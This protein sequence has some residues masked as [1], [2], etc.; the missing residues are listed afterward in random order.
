MPSVGYQNSLMKAS[1]IRCSTNSGRCS[2]GSALSCIQP[3]YSSKAGQFAFLCLNERIYLKAAKYCSLQSFHN[4]WG[5][6]VMACWTVLVAPE[7][8]SQMEAHAIALPW[9]SLHP[10]QWP[11]LPLWGD[12]DPL[13]LACGDGYPTSL[14]LSRTAPSKG[15]GVSI[16][17][18]RWLGLPPVPCAPLLCL[19]HE[20][21]PLVM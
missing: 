12:G 3:V 18:V 16:V 21:K 9:R 4:V 8:G 19:V 14:R 13:H 11:P 15:V 1:Y 6:P 7:S 2:G 10:W 20:Q 17:L 5:I